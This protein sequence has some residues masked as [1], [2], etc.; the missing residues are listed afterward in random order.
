M[1]KPVVL[2]TGATGTVGRPL[3]EQLLNEGVKVRAV[4]RNPLTAQLPENA[5]VIGGD[6]ACPETLAEAM[7]GVT[8]VFLNPIA[9]GDATRR[10]LELAQERGAI[11]VVMLSSAAVRDGVAEQP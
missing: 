5:E 10:L 3:V 11:R 2:V 7:A 4:T 1:G 9:V 8:A 6:P